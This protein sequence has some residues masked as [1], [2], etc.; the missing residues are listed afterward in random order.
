MEGINKPFVVEETSSMAEVWA[1][2]PDSLTATPWAVLF[3]EKHNK[4]NPRVNSSSFFI[5]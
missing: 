2:A 3:D 5:D 4:Y 1:A